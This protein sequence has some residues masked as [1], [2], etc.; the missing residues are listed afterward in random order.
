[1]KKAERPCPETDSC[2]CSEAARAEEAVPGSCCLALTTEPISRFRVSRRQSVKGRPHPKGDHKL[3]S[4]TALLG[5]PPTA[6]ASSSSLEPP[7]PLSPASTCSVSGVA[8]LAS[9]GSCPQPAPLS[10]QHDT[11]PCLSGYRDV[12]TMGFSECE[13]SRH[14]LGEKKSPGMDQKEERTWSLVL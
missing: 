14:S 12:S 3:S 10:S 4:V 2:P 6:K 9:S 7:P 13:R 8:L 11:V 5:V 1:M